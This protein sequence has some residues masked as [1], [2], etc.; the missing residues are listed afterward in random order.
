MQTDYQALE[1]QL[2]ALV[3][4]VPHLT[5][6]LANASALLYGALEDVNWV[7]FYL[8]EDGRLVLG[9]FQGRPACIEIPLTRGVCGTAADRDETLLVPDVSLFPGHIACDAASRS[10]LVIPLHGKRGV[11]GVLDIDSA[12]KDRFT[13]A[14]RAGLESLVRALEREL[15]EVL[16]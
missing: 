1:A 15:A 6:D 16:P 3:H 4:G 8:M 14:D 12:V 9:P 10:E 2:T 13:A 5:A 7:G 11:V